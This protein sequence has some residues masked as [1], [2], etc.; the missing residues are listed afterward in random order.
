MFVPEKEST[1]SSL[2]QTDVRRRTNLSTATNALRSAAVE[3][4]N[5]SLGL[6]S[7]ERLAEM[8]DELNRIV[9]R[10]VETLVEGMEEIID[11][12]SVGS[13][14][15]LRA[16]QDSLAIELRT[17][18]LVRSCTS[19]MALSHS[20]KMLWLLGDEANRRRIQD[21]R[22]SPLNSE[23]SKLKS[24]A[25]QLIE[26]LK[27]GP[28]ADSSDH[29]MNLDPSPPSPSNAGPSNPSVHATDHM[30]T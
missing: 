14:D 17:E 22:T 9:D 7:E 1:N 15:K 25:A 18:T 10:D 19:L 21:A 6:S 13:V 29:E 23:I 3:A 20:M 5:D 8:E 26:E 30:P 11:L 27:V 12:S 24:R 16:L 4:Q 2:F 28:P